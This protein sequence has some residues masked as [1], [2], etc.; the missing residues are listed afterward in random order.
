MQPGHR[1]RLDRMRE[2]FCQVTGTPF[3]HFFC[4]ILHVDE[5]A[6]LAMGHIIPKSLG[7]RESVL[8]RADVD[9]RFGSFV[10]AEFA[11]I[12][13]YG[14]DKT[15]ASR[16]MSRSAPDRKR[17]SRFKASIELKESGEQIPLR[18]AQ[19][20]EGFVVRT[21][22]DLGK[23]KDARFVVEMDGRS[24]ALVTCVRSHHLW[25]FRTLGYGYVFSVG[26]ELTAAFLRPLGNR[27][28][29]PLPS[30]MGS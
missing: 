19:G 27:P 16:V 6:P 20:G 17:L 30:G 23:L 18:P 4:P 5:R 3:E 26:G 14:S 9:N 2:D 15:L 12:I 25:A 1:R 21:N 29:G 8:Q 10:E 7:G 24:S 13:R 28:F 22:A 11:D